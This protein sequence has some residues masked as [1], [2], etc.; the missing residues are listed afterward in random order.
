M[1]IAVR[2][3]LVKPENSFDAERAGENLAHFIDALDKHGCPAGIE[4]ICKTGEL[5]RVAPALLHP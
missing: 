2:R 5:D 4:A 3:S 1:E